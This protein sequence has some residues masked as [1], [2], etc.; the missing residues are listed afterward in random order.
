MEKY[1]YEDFNGNHPRPFYTASILLPKWAFQLNRIKK[2]QIYKL[3]ENVNTILL[4]L[5]S[6]LIYIFVFFYSIELKSPLRE[7]Q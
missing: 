4:Y 2:I 3:I 7:H 6:Q 5:H 1:K